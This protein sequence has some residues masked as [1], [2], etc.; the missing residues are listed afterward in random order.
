VVSRYGRPS[1]HSL[2]RRSQVR[3]LV[4]LFCG[5]ACVRACVRACDDD[6]EVCSS[7]FAV[8]SSRMLHAQK[9]TC[10]VESVATMLLF[11]QT[12]SMRRCDDAAVRTCLTQR[13]P[14][15]QLSQKVLCA[16]RCYGRCTC[17]RYDRKLAP[18]VQ[19][20]LHDGHTQHAMKMLKFANT[21]HA[22]HEVSIDEFAVVLTMLTMTCANCSGRSGRRSPP[23]K[24][25]SQP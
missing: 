25:S 19:L 14:H 20:S 23:A 13:K 11:A 17:A 4:P 8:R 15:V 3:I 5:F 24:S 21:P 18:H 7:Q 22:H 16:T 9:A 12:A 1:G 2:T 6:A 10:A